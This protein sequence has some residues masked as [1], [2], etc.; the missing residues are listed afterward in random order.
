MTHKT[1][2]KT[3]ASVAGG[4]KRLMAGSNAGLNAVLIVIIFLMLNY[5]AMRHYARWDWTASGLYTLSEKSAS[6]LKSLDKDVNVYVMWGESG[7]LFAD[8]KELLD[9]YGALSSRFKVEY[10]DP[11][12]DPARFKMIVDTHGAKMR[13]VAGGMMAFEA[14]VI[15]TCNDRTK[16]ISS[17]DIE[18][19][20]EEMG[21]RKSLSSFKAEQA[22]TSAILEVTSEKQNKVCFTQGHEEWAFEGV[23]QR[24]LGHVIEN[25][26]QDNYKSEAVATM[27]AARISAD[28]DLLAVIGPSRPFLKDEAELIRRYREGGGSVFLLLDP[29][30]E[31]T[32]F[33]PTGLEDLAQSAGIALDQNLVLEPDARRLLTIGGAETFVASSFSDHEAVRHLSLPEGTPEEIREQLGAL[34]VGFSTARSLSLR[35]GA[36]P[37]VHILAEASEQSWG[38]RDLGFMISGIEPTMG[39]GDRTGPC[40]IA[41]ASQPEESEKTGR[42]IVVGD[43]DVLN[44]RFFVNE[45]FLNRDFFSGAVA[46]LTKQ[47]SLI[48]IAPKNPE[49]VKLTL[50]QDELTNMELV[51]LGLMPVLGIILGIMVWRRR[52]S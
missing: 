40:V 50:T 23:G 44:E 24:G 20:S 26:K 49:H 10:V 46:W 47:E 27:G 32:R 5:L 12:R 41:A 42:M 9:R 34:P 11:D 30:V 13:E 14:S 7:P 51:T 2:K 18:D 6:I 35:E 29:V 37:R 1:E 15:F 28:C 8:V 22:F 48:S 45:G 38:E 21:S 31:G 17:Y 36:E 52:R 25:L 19:Y 16:F 4:S 39:S 43:S 3:Q 33:L